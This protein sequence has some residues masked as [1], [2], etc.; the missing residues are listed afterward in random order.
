MNHL[1]PPSS[2]SSTYTQ[3]CATLPPNGEPG[4]RVA[5]EVMGHCQSPESRGRARRA[6]DDK[7]TGPG[8]PPGWRPQQRRAPGASILA[9]PRPAALAAR[10]LRGP[11]RSCPYSPRGKQRRGARLPAAAWWRE[12]AGNF[13]CRHLRI[14]LSEAGAPR[15]LPGVVVLGSLSRGD[16]G[17]RTAAVALDRS[18]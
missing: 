4:W 11:P 16:K 1:L 10:A 12:F 9:Y 15:G 13:A 2:S 18:T 17:Q 7:V 3:D 14:A 5:A 8:F 6:P